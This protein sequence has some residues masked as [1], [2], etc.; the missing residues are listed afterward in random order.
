MARK[1]SD[2]IVMYVALCMSMLTTK[3]PRRASRAHTVRAAPRVPPR[4]GVTFRCVFN[5]WHY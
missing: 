4:R 2:L 3:L 1:S 5:I